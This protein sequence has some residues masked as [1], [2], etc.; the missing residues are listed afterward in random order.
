[1]AGEAVDPD[2]VVPGAAGD[3]RVVGQRGADMGDDVAEVDRAGGAGRRGIIEVLPAG[4]FQP[5]GAVRRAVGA[6]RRR[7]LHEA[8]GTGIDQQIGLIDLAEFLGAGRDMDNLLARAR[9][10]EQ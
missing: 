8:H 3:H 6:E 2:G 1:M 9:H 5:G 10:R 7:H 4:P